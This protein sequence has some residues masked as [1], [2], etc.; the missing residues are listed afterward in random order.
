M[1]LLV[2]ALA[3]TAL[4]ASGCSNACQDLGDRLCKCTPLGTTKASCVNGVKAEVSRLNPNKDEQAVCAEKLSTCWARNDPSTGQPIDFCDWVDGRCGKAAC[5][6]SEE[7]YATLS[8]T[9][10]TTGAP[11]TPDPANPAAPLCPQ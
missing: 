6:M 11:I 10:A 1:R 3:T 5:G 2:L 7:E 9:D 8:G 4:L